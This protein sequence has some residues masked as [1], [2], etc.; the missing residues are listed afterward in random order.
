MKRFSS[1]FCVAAI[2]LGSCKK[3]PEKQTELAVQDF[4]RNRVSD[5]G[6]YFPGKF[7]HQP[8]TRR[9]SLLYLAEMAQN[10]SN[11]DFRLKSM[12]PA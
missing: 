10:I 5:A 1:L 3:S 9:D 11:F 7:R 2:L 8:Y 4:V 6:N 12:L